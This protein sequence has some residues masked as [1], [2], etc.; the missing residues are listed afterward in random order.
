MSTPKTDFFSVKEKILHSLLQNEVMIS[1]AL[2]LYCYLLL[3]IE[4]K[5]YAQKH[6]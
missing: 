2:A 5:I 6:F 3:E 1:I 4:K